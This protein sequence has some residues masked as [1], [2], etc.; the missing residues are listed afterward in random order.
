MS[1]AHATPA[2]PIFSVSTR[3]RSSPTFSTEEKIN[4]YSGTLERPSALNMAE[5]TLYI[6]KKGRPRK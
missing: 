6:N 5:S 1:V 4:R 2:T 3:Y